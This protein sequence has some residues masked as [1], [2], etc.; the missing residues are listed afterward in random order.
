VT[1]PAE[2]LLL[3]VSPAMLAEAR[4]YC[5]ELDRQRGDNPGIRPVAGLDARARGRLAELALRPWLVANDRDLELNGGYDTKPDAIVHGARVGIRFCGNRT[6]YSPSH[7]VYVFDRHLTAG[8]EWLFVGDYSP[9]SDAP[10][11]LLLLGACTLSELLAGRA[12]PAGCELVPGFTAADP[13]HALRVAQLEAPVEWLRRLA[14]EKLQRL[15]A[16]EAIP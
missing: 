7:S 15:A 16:L 9:R 4:D 10:R 1:Y 2:W 12:V 11:A 3:P 5:D 8:D 6:H 13:L 14:R